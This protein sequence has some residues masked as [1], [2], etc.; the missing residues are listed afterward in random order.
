MLGADLFTSKFRRVG[1]W[2]V[3]Y[4]H[5]FFFVVLSH[6]NCSVEPEDP[7]VTTLMEH[8]KNVI[9]GIADGKWS[10]LT[11]KWISKKDKQKLFV[12]DRIQIQAAR[13]LDM[14][15][16]PFLLTTGLVKSF[17]DFGKGCLRVSGN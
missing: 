9:T 6:F 3:D 7:A 5:H 16:Q 15:P 14:D 1:G 2:S 11:S 10:Q 4:L 12:M 17:A 8:F 13:V